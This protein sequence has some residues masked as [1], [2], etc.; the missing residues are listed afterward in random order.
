MSDSSTLLDKLSVSALGLMAMLSEQP[1]TG[2]ELKKM[3][4]KPEFIYWRDSFGSIY[5]NLRK[6]TGL[7]LAK[8]ARADLSGRRRIVYSLTDKGRKLV[9]EWLAVPASKKPLKIELLLKLRF[10]YPLGR[11]AIL[12][13]L[14]EH[15]DYYKSKL[16]DCYENL[17]YLEGFDDSSLQTETQQINADF[18]YRLTRMLV[19]WSESSISRMDYKG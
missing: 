4:D 7:K 15:R 16:P 8:K 2:Y 9:R 5:P 12:K 6:I 14:W 19:E 11:D 1:M 18:W 17:Q 13:L 3:V 10:A